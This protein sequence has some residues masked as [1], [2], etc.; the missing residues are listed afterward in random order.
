MPKQQQSAS[1]AKPKQRNDVAP[2]HKATPEDAYAA[3][4]R[5]FV[6]GRKLDMVA[7]AGSLGVGRATLYRWT[8]PREQLMT[9]VLATFMRDAFARIEQRLD[10]AGLNGEERVAR[11][12]EEM[13]K[14]LA[15][16]APVQAM[17]R[18]EPDAAL[19]ILTGGAPGSLQAESIAHLASIIERE[20]GRSTYRPRLEPQ[21]LAYTAVR[22]IYSFVYGDLIARIPVNLRDASIVLRSLL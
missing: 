3:A 13:I 11:S 15:Q 1:P 17:L 19:R 18:N 7:L 14:I 8:G 10:K 21:L 16:S 5:A 9:A 22:L 20:M 6:Q 12:L 2:K 4:R